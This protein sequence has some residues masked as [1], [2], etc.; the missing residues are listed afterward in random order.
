MQEEHVVI[1]KML[2]TLDIKWEVLNEVHLLLVIGASQL[3]REFS[4]Q[5]VML[6]L[7]PDKILINPSALVSVMNGSWRV[8]RNSLIHI[9]TPM[10]MYHF[11]GKIL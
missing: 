6:T 4:V 2:W 5:N 3:H 7:E 11:A 10:K 1:A 8:K 9:L